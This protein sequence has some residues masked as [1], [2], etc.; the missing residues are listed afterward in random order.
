MAKTYADIED[1]VLKNINSTTADVSFAIDN[2][3]DFLG[4]FYENYLIDTSIATV[5]GQDYIARPALCK[6]VERLEIDGVEIKKGTVA[7]LEEIKDFDLDRFIEYDGKINLYPTPDGVE[8]TK[9]W[10]KALFTPLAGVAAAETDVPDQLIPLLVSI[11][12]W[13]FLEQQENMY[14]YTGGDGWMP[15]TDAWTF[16]N[17]VDDPTFT[18][19]VP[20][21]ATSLYGV[22]MKIK[23]VQTTTKYF[24]ITKVENTVLTVFGGTDYNL[25]NA[26][27]SQIY[28]S[29][30]RC[31]RLFPMDPNKWSI[32]LQDTIDRAQA[33]PAINTW[34][35][36]GSLAITLPIGLWHIEYGITVYCLRGTA[37]GLQAKISL[38]TNAAAETNAALSM[39]NQI[40]SVQIDDMA[41]QMFNKKLLT[42]TAKTVYYIIIKTS[43]ANIGSLYLLGA[44]G[45]TTE[46]KAICAYL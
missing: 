18:I 1:R 11:A 24:I 25:T 41:F 12:T 29:P 20:A 32:I 35:N 31:P 17:D 23:L 27:I 28:Y 16:L 34:Y 8:T 45:S 6:E 26:V 44:T 4:N 13:F 46:V 5:A 3:I 37:T 14:D 38:S 42:M 9:I 10:F 33:T 43:Y 15:V 39:Y 30:S 19:T 21:G 36:P 22:G 2:A 40:T 7:Q